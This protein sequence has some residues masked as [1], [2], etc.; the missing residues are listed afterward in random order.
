[1]KDACDDVPLVGPAGKVP[2]WR[3]TKATKQAIRERG[4]VTKVY[5]RESETQ[6]PGRS[7]AIGGCERIGIQSKEINAGKGGTLNNDAASCTR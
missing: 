2:R 5:R 3:G 6:C 1:V 7:V 4:I